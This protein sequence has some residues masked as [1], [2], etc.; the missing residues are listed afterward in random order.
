MTRQF[1]LVKATISEQG[2]ADRQGSGICKLKRNQN[3]SEF[4]TQYTLDRGFS[5]LELY[6]RGSSTAAIF[7][8]DTQIMTWNFTVYG[9]DDIMQA[10]VNLSREELIRD[11]QEI[12][13]L[14]ELQ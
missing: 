13:P 6:E 3:L 12:L 7:R 10:I 8:T 5:N 2:F 11:L 1:V 14:K 4:I 9:E